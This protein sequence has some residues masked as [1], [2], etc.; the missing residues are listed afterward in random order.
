MKKTIHSLI[1]FVFFLALTETTY[2]QTSKAD[3]KKTIEVKATEGKGADPNVKKDKAK[4]N[5]VSQKNQTTP[6]ATRGSVYGSDYCD[7]TIDNWTSYILDIYVDGDY[8][9]TIG[10][11]DN[12]VTWAVPGRTKLYARAVFDDGSYSAWGPTYIDAGYSYT[13][14][15]KP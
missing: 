12:R 6:P 1:A 15:L 2:S 8:R 4:S 14:K 3:K 9:G 7:V 10:P 11:W 5:M 13:W